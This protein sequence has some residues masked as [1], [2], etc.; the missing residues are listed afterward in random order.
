MTEVQEVELVDGYVSRDL[1][2]AG[3]TIRLFKR[4][5]RLNEDGTWHGAPTSHSNPN[6]IEPEVA[7]AVMTPD[8]FVES[9][10]YEEGPD[11]D[12]PGDGLPNYGDREPWSFEV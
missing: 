10:E 9:Y 8:E 11:D 3:G 5:P 4:L 7:L 2:D 6:R 12:D 1:E